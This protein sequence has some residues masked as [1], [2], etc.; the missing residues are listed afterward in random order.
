MLGAFVAEIVWYRDIEA[1][2]FRHL[3]DAITVS[4]RGIDSR[5]RE[6]M[7]GQSSYRPLAKTKTA[8]TSDHFPYRVL[9]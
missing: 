9:R 7:N 4:N 2:Q 1:G 8:P 5:A 3:M 6:I